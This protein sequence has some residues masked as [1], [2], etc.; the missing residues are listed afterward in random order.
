MIDFNQH[1]RHCYIKRYSLIVP[2][3]KCLKY[4]S[5]VLSSLTII[6][7]IR[8]QQICVPFITTVFKCVVLC[9]PFVTILR[10]FSHN[11]YSKWKENNKDKH[12]YLGT[13]IMLNLFLVIVHR[14]FSLN[15]GTIEI[16]I[17]L[18]KLDTQWNLY[19]SNT[20]QNRI[21]MIF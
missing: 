1:A 2:S 6:L 13:G 16:D 11:K 17:I 9:F 8:C 10:G 19:M 4:Q 14:L 20:K 18:R 21:Q 3:L 15:Y 7:M 12:S 5:T